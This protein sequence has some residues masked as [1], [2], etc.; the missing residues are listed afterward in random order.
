MDLVDQ[1]TSLIR[2]LECN[3]Q[4]IAMVRFLLRHT[5]QDHEYYVWVI[6][7]SPPQC[8]DVGSNMKLYILLLYT[9]GDYPTL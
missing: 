8:H 2:G 3:P 9:W 7:P 6:I 1:W 5:K 4:V